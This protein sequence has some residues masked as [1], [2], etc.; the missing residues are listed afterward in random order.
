MK[1]AGSIYF[2]IPSKTTIGP[3]TVKL[4]CKPRIENGSLVIENYVNGI[5]KQQQKCSLLRQL[6]ILSI[7]AIKI[8]NRL[9]IIPANNISSDVF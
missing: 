5:K 3:I 1:N 2:N 6:I 7:P 9:A 8:R 4:I